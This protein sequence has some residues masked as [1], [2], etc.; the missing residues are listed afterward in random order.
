M[1][2]SVMRVLPRVWP[3]SGGVEAGAGLAAEK[4]GTLTGERDRLRK[5]VR[6]PE[7]ER[8]VSSRPLRIP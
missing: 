1:E 2:K 7:P 3:R 8:E 6:E 5:Q 4:P